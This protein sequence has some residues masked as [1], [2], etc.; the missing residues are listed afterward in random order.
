[1]SNNGSNPSNTS[2]DGSPPDQTTTDEPL[3]PSGIAQF[4]EHDRCPRY[5]KQ[6]VNPGDESDARDW[7]EAFGLVNCLGVKPRGLSVDSRSIR[8]TRQ[9]EIGRSRSLSL[10]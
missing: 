1:M 6:R 10:T 4:V 2:R 5:L 9:A 7:R 3:D 8:V